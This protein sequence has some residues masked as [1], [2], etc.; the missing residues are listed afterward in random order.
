[1]S[2]I[3]IDAIEISSDDSCNEDSDEENSDERILMK[4]IKYTSFFRKNK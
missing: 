4:N 1:M 2:K 3:I